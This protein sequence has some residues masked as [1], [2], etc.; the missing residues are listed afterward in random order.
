M[1][2]N[3]DGSKADNEETKKSSPNKTTTQ[4]NTVF[5][6]DIVWNHHDFDDKGGKGY[7]QVCP[8]GGPGGLICCFSCCKLY[9]S[10]LSQTA[11]DIEI[12]KQH[13]TSNEIREIVDFLKE[14]C[15][16]LES[17][18]QRASKKIPPLPPKPPGPEPDDGVLI[19]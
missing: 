7:D 18:A 13:K 4:Q 15:E 17:A 1:K 12:Q 16:T 2:D 6:K 19:I 10:Y 5:V 8:E 9:S 3:V 14:S 11:K